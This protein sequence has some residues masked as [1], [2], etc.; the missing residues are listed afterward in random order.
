MAINYWSAFGTRAK[1][2][3]LER[4]ARSPQYADGRFV[5]T[6]PAL[7]MGMTWSSVKEWFFGDDT[8]RVPETPVPV[9]R[10]AAAD[11]AA[12]A[13]D[14]RVTW[15]GHSSLLVE[16]DGARI[17]VDPVWSDHASP[18]PL[19]GV[20]RFHAPPL[21]LEDLPPLDAVVISHDH[22]D[23]LDERTM[24]ALAEHVPLFLVPL[25]VGAHL[26]YWGVPP[27]RIV[28]LD[29]WERADVGGVEVV[30]TP[31]RHFSGRF[32][33]DRNATL[34]ASWAFLGA[35]RRAFFS[36]DSALFPGFEEIGARLGPFDLAM[37]EVGAYNASWADVHMGPEQAVAAHQ[38]VR[39]GLLVPVHW[40]TFNL[41]FHTWTEPA[42]R[43]RVAAEQVGVPLALPRPG[44]SITI[45]DPPALES[46]WP[47]LPWQT[48]EEAPVVSSGLA[49]QT[50]ASSI[51]P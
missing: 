3:R 49:E 10:R 30:C 48:A 29:W 26:E 5:N 17:L 15:L 16:L 11:F 4:V 35:E 44:E 23:H 33:N 43:V 14:L 22:Y 7:N 27:E 51:K 37:I 31:A 24:K 8:Y 40:G 2:P 39:G 47:D 46:W 6:L 21:P 41:A 18:G 38:M 45:G 19:F 12:P 1:G 25:G 32:L 20:K 36:G 34:W 9:V 42:E 28:E 13:A 50:S